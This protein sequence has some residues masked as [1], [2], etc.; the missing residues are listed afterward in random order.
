M[1]WRVRGRVEDL[2]RLDV[3]GLMKLN[4]DREKVMQ[5]INSVHAKS[6]YSHSSDDCCPECKKPGKASCALYYMGIEFFA[7]FSLP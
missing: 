2:G 4:A 5:E 6:V 1:E 3:F 7:T